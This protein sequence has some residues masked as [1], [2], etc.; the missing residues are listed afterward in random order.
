MNVYLEIGKKRTFAG[1]LE[2]PG[3][4]RSGKNEVAALQ[5]LFDYRLRY[6]QAIQSAQLGFEPPEE[7][8]A[9]NVVE[10]LEGNAN[11]DFGAPAVAPSFDDGPAGEAELRRYRAL[12][13]AMWR[14]FDA[15]AQGAEGK[16]LRKGPRGGGQWTAATSC[17]ALQGMCSTRPG[18]SK[19]DSDLK[20]IPYN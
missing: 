2:W 15:V 12:L 14:A 18:R 5:T 17:G 11:T 9:I 16:E 1:A 20:I 6:A 8:S 13:E 10:R 7:L 19:T 3:W 4:C